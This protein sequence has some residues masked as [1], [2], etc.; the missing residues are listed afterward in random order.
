MKNQTKMWS[1][2]N[3][4]EENTN[5]GSLYYITLF[6]TCCEFLEDQVSIEFYNIN[7][8]YLHPSS[9]G[10]VH[11]ILISVLIFSFSPVLALTLTFLLLTTSI[12]IEQT[13]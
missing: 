4:G 12:K 9:P 13:Q 8:N 6:L 10:H 3:N 11:V 2:G 1:T 7:M 5:S